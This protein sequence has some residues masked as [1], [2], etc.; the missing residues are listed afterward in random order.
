MSTLPVGHIVGG[1]R[2]IRSLGRGGMSSIYLAYQESVNRDVVLKVLPDSLT[3]DPTFMTRFS[4]EV[5]T[6]VRLQHPHIVPIYDYGEQDGLPYIVMAYLPGGSVDDLIAEGPLSLDETARIVGQVGEALDYAHEMGVI[7][8]DIKP[9]NILLDGKHN[10]ILT[11]FGIAK[12][13]ADTLELTEEDK[14]VGTISYLAPELIMPNN[15][16]T[17]AVDIYAL[18]ITLYQI[19]TGKL[20]F[21]SQTSAQ[22]L[23]CH[24]NEP[25]P[26]L[27]SERPDLPPALDA[28]VQRAMAK[29]S[30]ARIQSAA[31]L[32]DQLADIASGDFQTVEEPV[33]ETVVLSSS[34]PMTRLE[35]SVQQVLDQVVK[36][37]RPDGG[38]GSGI[39]LPGGQVVTTLH[40]VDGSPG[41][42]IRF[43]NGEQAEADVM[44]ADPAQDLALLSL[45]AAPA[46]I[47]TGDTFRLARISGPPNPGAA[48]VAIGHPLGLDWAVTG[49]HYNGLHQ[50]ENE[51][52]TRLG[53]TLDVPLVQVDVTINAGNSGGPVIDAEGRLVGLADSVIN[54]AVANNIGFAIYAPAVWDFWEANREVE[55]PLVAF[56]CKHHHPAGTAYCPR[57]GRPIVPA[58]PIPM[59]T[60]ESTPYTCGH[61]HPPGL[62]FCPL[63]GK[64]ILPTSD[65]LA[66]AAR[67]QVRNKPTISQT[68][69]NC[70]TRFEASL[71][72][73]PHCGKPVST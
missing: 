58:A 55:A 52:L 53:I 62:T 73:C 10:A 9:A 13:I 37:I 57:T 72:Y 59:P 65:D 4:T 66:Q 23:W 56:D 71:G 15:T 64:P 30:A 1:C 63:I 36:I 31:E 16:I 29:S 68:C 27:T 11:D 69:T 26:L 46:S 49:G 12:V 8:R 48:L 2:V 44:A 32:A 38:T 5:A 24:V 17:P 47:D 3:G 14:I 6:T 34:E 19:L 51:P 7:H 20:P 22:M 45:R 43:R 40:V 18:G 25:A 28:L 60:A 50:P 61:R 21:E 42:Y 67:T 33:P 39:T 35:H 70:G 41:V 54:P